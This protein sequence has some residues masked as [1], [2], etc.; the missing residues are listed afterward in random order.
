M[1]KNELG[2]P[3]DIQ[4]G[5]PFIKT[6]CKYLF[7]W[8]YFSI[9]YFVFSVWHISKTRQFLGVFCTFEGG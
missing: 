9:V 5:I 6:A 2:I 4:L 8:A 3:L 7:S 1:L